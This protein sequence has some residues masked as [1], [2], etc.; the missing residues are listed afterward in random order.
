MRERKRGRRGQIDYENSR[1]FK[2]RIS[3]K[4]G[5][6]TRA[7]NYKNYRGD[8]RSGGRGGGEDGGN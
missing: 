2:N 3:K 7:K 4:R 6:E 8:N 5:E 1:F